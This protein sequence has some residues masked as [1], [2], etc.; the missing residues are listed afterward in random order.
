MLKG[1]KTVSLYKYIFILLTAVVT[2]LS[3][4]GC[5]SSKQE[6]V[7]GADKKMTA[8][9]AGEEKE[10]TPVDLENS[11]P[12]KVEP[13]KNVSFFS[14]AD[15]EVIKEIKIG[16]PQ[17]LRRAVLKFKKAQIDFSESEITLYNIAQAFM[18]MAYPSE[19]PL[20]NVPQVKKTNN[21]IGMLNSAKSG[22]Y[23]YNPEA[24]EFFDYVIPCLVLCTSTVKTDY[25][26]SAERALNA[27]LSKNSDSVLCNYLLGKLYVKKGEYAKAISCFD[28]ATE[29]NAIVFEILF[30]K[31]NCL[32]KLKKYDQVSA[33]LDKLV[34]QFPSDVKIL[35]LYA[36][37][38]FLMNDYQKAEQ[39]AS[40]VLQQ[41]PSD[42]EFILFRAKI[43]VEIAEYLKASALLDVYSKTYPD[44]NEY[45]LLRAR[46]QKEW[47]KNLN[48]AV[49]T[50]EHA[51]T[52]YPS[53]IDVILYAAELAS[54]TGAKINGK[55]GGEL[56]AVIL[57]EDSSNQKALRVSAQSY[58]KEEN[59]SQAYA[60]SKRM[61]G[62]PYVPQ[63]GILLHIKIC[64]AAKYNEEAW[65]YAVSV[66]E[67]NNTDPLAIQTYIDVMRKTGRTAAASRMINN[68]LS[69]NPLASMKSYLLYER[70]F[71]QGTENA[72]LADLRSSLIAN[73]RNSE[74]LFR[75]YQIY[76]NRKDYKK[77]QYYLKQVVSL[78]PNNE[79][80]IKLNAEI[81]ALVK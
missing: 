38:A 9:Y 13:K 57:A 44:K 76:Y 19:K 43:F 35:K 23:E 12:I 32:I 33:I 14:S 53:D 36:T 66:Y 72:Q 1:H 55:N 65:K 62:L 2:G 31:A 25:Y 18:T 79:K 26:D 3:V 71:L 81:E 45:L 70:S 64:L 69:S 37:T 67:K 6:T 28:K 51:L 27:A 73:P 61:M 29:T 49:V 5:Q 8:S 54:E 22:I 58:F 80:Y 21:Y 68:L 17:A 39:Y 20:E 50:I 78:N 41:N 59:Y 42:L 48:A 52:L 63:E 34:I 46:I 16:S 7:A 75:M 74:A 47:N 11:T 30:E 24:K 40:L 77:A 4:S 56:A 10:E 15:D 60:M